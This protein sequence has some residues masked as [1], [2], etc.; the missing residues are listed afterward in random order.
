MIHRTKRLQAELDLRIPDNLAAT[1]ASHLRAPQ[2]AI[3]KREWVA[4]IE[5]AR[6]MKTA[7]KVLHMSTSS[8]LMQIVNVLGDQ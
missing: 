8:P 7:V 4:A 1:N 5:T 2:E 6:T 3:R